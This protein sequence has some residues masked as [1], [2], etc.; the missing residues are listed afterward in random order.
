LSL[1]TKALGLFGRKLNPEARF[2]R[3][4][5][6]CVHDMSPDALFVRLVQGRDA[7]YIQIKK[8]L[9]ILGSDIW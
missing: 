2:D 8:G 3:G 7:G 5:S 9:C 1:Q 6:C 4:R